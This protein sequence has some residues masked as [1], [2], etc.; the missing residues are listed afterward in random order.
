MSI[1]AGENFELKLVRA[2]DILLH[3]E[4]DD[5]RYIRL[6]E[7]FDEEKVLFNPLILG[8]HKEQF[9]LIDGANR[10]EALRRTGCKIILAQLV[11]YNSPEVRLKSWYHF[12]NG[13]DL[14]GLKAF[15][16]TA[17]IDHDS[18]NSAE[19]LESFNSVGVVSA[20]GEAIQ[21]KC[22]TAFSEILITLCKLN[23]YYESRYS[24][25]RIDSDTDVSDVGRLSQE[26]GL[27]FVYPDFKKEHILQIAVSAQK[28]PA[29]ITRHLIPN[30]VLHIKILIE[31]LKTDEHL[32]KRN[33]ELEK[34]IQYKIDTQK[35]RLYRE[36]ILVFDE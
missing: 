23:K 32:D 16:E 21:I 33:E 31:A 7:R 20:S 15:L 17:K 35:V 2:S 3:E 12:V 22:S 27:L 36:P 19:G 4:C 34:F 26:D 14:N 5:N 28:L 18:W 13:L 25:I 6:V 10:F 8:R 11:D 30:R 9:V 24:Y 29:G 1:L